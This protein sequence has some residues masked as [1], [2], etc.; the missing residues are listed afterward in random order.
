[1]TVTGAD[2]PP[3]RQAW[4]DPLPGVRTWPADPHPWLGPACLS[5]CAV[6]AALAA[7]AGPWW[8]A[9]A[10]PAAFV[11]GRRTRRA[12]PALL[13]FASLVS[14]GVVVASVLPAW[15]GPGLRLASVTAFAGVLPWLAGRFARQY[16]EL[17]WAG[18]ERADRLAREHRLLADQVRLRE[19]ARIAQDVHDS[20]GH[21][22]SLIALR[23]G[24]LKMAPGLD[25]RHREAAAD[26]RSAA[27]TAVDR[28]AAAIGLLR[29]GLPLTTPDP[30]PPIAAL[31]ERAARWGIQAHLDTDGKPLAIPHTVE[32][33]AYH[34]VQEALTNV[35]KH[36][37]HPTAHIHLHHTPT[38][39]TLSIRS[40]LSPSGPDRRTTTSGTDRRETT[41]GR[42][43]PGLEERVRRAGGRFEYGRR[44][45]TFT[46]VAHLPHAVPP[47]LAAP[48][49]Q[50]TSDQS[51]PS[52][53]RSG[54]QVDS[55]PSASPSHPQADT[56]PSLNPPH[57]QA[58]THPSANP[59]HPQADTRSKVGRFHSQV[60]RGIPSAWW[61]RRSAGS[62]PRVGRLLAG[63]VVPPLVAF[64]VLAAAL[65]GWDVFLVSRSV[66]DP[67][68]FARLR[69]GQDRAQIARLLP[70]RELPDPPEHASPPA[71]GTTCEYYAATANPL[72]NRYGDAYT[73]CFRGP[74]LLTAVPPPTPTTGS[75]SPAS[76][77]TT[78][79]PP[80]MP[81]TTADPPRTAVAATDSRDA[82]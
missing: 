33:T 15:G 60:D 76:D 8:S 62:R 21:D 72:G 3:P 50:A 12:R 58:N 65:K 20:L 17:V 45:D 71:P 75:L 36:A 7:V 80:A 32:R 26:I 64:A 61:V 53:S 5:V 9:L 66:L 73:L 81:T 27:A 43:L 69:P 55:L 74:T 16:Q 38:Q 22:L 14:L 54:P 19:R 78:E 67:A 37:P 77:S 2:R 18:W 39:T 6:A 1:M 51:P 68:D 82:G 11:A 59:P 44:D 79:A 40:P 63:A 46:L 56:H 30:A 49:P 41:G 13:V 52:A 25:D 48:S 28:L 42:G 70:A 23:A 35:A 4:E 57:P 10:V 29:D 47:H 31:V 24:A 34:V